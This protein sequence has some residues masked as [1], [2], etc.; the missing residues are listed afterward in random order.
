MMLAG[1]RQSFVRAALP[2]MS[3]FRGC[4]PCPAR[5]MPLSR[6]TAGGPAPDFPVD[7]V[8]TW[9][10]GSD[11]VLAAKRAAHLPPGER[12]DALRQGENLYRDND[13]LRY[14]LRSLDRYAPW[15]RRVF[16]VTD[17]QRPAWLAD[18]SRVRVVDHTEIIPAEYL[19]TFSSRVIEAFLHRIPDLGERYI[20][21]NDDFFLSAPCSPGDF[22]T[23]NGLPYLFTDWRR[24]R[25]V[26]YARAATPHTRSHANVRRYLEASGIRPTPTLITAHGPFP[27]TRR[28]A[29]D[30]YAF[31]E[32][33][34]REF[35]VDKFRSFRGMVFY[36]HM[37]P[38]WAYAMGR[39]VP[40][41]VPYY[42]IDIKRP[43]RLLYYQAL[44]QGRGGD[45]LPLFFCLNDTQ[46][47]PGATR[48]R[49]DMAAFLQTGYPDPS[50][51]ERARTTDC[52]QASTRENA[53]RTAET[54]DGRL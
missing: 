54:R 25:R 22:F 43:D 9:V 34:V 35:A 32:A 21:F 13:E 18:H 46:T 14:S 36:C 26:S 44:I 49:E 38:L 33:A 3:P 39:G 10:D 20:Y 41:D 1:L 51:F 50:P 2:R 24:P 15:V 31:Y 28:N 16:I 47:W 29:A 5:L 17:G 45:C 48:W 53:A 7:V 27:Q 6:R 8:Y 4:D 30:A 37:L 40:C 42:Y 11:P 19:P 12:Y 23:P 52:P